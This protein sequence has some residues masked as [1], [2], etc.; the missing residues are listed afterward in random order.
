MERNFIETNMSIDI[1]CH[2]ECHFEHIQILLPLKE[3]YFEFPP[4]KM[5]ML[6][7]KM[8]PL[9]QMPLKRCTCLMA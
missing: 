1:E 6:A 3:I 2:T 8:F 5:Y 9:L 4:L 7:N